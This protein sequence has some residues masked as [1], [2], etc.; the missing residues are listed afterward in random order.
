MLRCKRHCP[1]G[2]KQC[3]GYWRL[4]WNLKTQDEDPHDDELD[5]WLEASLVEGAVDAC[6]QVLETRRAV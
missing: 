5:L 1:S 6:A 4:E 3:K 2:E